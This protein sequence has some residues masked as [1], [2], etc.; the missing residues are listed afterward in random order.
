M[1]LTVYEGMM[2]MISFAS[3][4]IAVLSFKDKK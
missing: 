1:P 2:I 4:I 3:L